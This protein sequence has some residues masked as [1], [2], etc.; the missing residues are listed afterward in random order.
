MSVIAAT[1][2]GRETGGGQERR[3]QDQIFFLKKG[4][5]PVHGMLVFC[6]KLQALKENRSLSTSSS[7]FPVRNA[8]IGWLIKLLCSAVSH[9]D[10]I[11]LPV[12]LPQLRIRGD[13]TPVS[14]L[15]DEQRQE[16]HHPLATK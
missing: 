3:E 10:K 15:R 11:A 4:Y 7:D 6:R 9:V 1:R 12:E 2:T 5:Q 13:G 16:L 14:A 8:K